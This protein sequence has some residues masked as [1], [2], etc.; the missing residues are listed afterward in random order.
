[1]FPRDRQPVLD[2]WVRGELT[3]EAFLEQVGWNEVW[4]YDAA[5]YLP[6]F[7]FARQM[8][9][10]MVALNVD[11]ALVGRVGREGWAAVPASER[12]GIGDP[13]APSEAYRRSLANVFAFKKQIGTQPPDAGTS[14]PDPSEADVAEVLDDPAFGRFVDAQLLWDRA[15]AEAMATALRRDGGPLVVGIVD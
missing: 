4:G 9:V 7:Q 14:F 6:L 2:A 13:A 11:R 15:M 3:P 12:A 10:P 1:M 5:F 8:R